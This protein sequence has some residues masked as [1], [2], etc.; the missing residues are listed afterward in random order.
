MKRFGKLLA[1]LSSLLI[2][3]AC[4][5]GGGSTPSTGT[6]DPRSFV[7]ELPVESS[8]YYN[9]T[10]QETAM[11]RNIFV[12]SAYAAENGIIA[13]PSLANNTIHDWWSVTW[14]DLECSVYDVADETEL[15]L[16]PLIGATMKKLVVGNSYH[17]II[18]ATRS[19]QKNDCSYGRAVTGEWTFDLAVSSGTVEEN[20]AYE[21][22]ETGE[23]V[24]QLLDN[25]SDYSVPIVVTVS[26]T[27]MDYNG[28]IGGSSQFEIIK[29]PQQL[30]KVNKLKFHNTDVKWK[31]A[32]YID[33]GKLP[34]FVNIQAIGPHI[35]KTSWISNTGGLSSGQLESDTWNWAVGHIDDNYDC[36]VILVSTENDDNVLI[37]NKMVVY[38]DERDLLDE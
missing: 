16:N 25:G 32:T 5:G 36:M 10:T 3:A 28:A 2:I 20:I 14:P 27:G 6:A 26:Y 31:E 38:G 8:S 17:M 37:Q 23:L 21:Q 22:F 1:I 24:I 4:G 7:V 11:L 29:D 15:I 9:S 33:F 34:E 35:S 30:S 18:E 12:K 13:L 19:E